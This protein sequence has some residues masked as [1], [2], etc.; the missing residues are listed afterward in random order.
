MVRCLI[1]ARRPGVS[2]FRIL[3]A[4]AIALAMLVPLGASSATSLS[5]EPHA[6]PARAAAPRIVLRR[7]VKVGHDPIKI[8]RSKKAKVQLTFRGKKGQFLNLALWAKGYSSWWLRPPCASW[9]LR[10]NHKVIKAKA[11]GYWKVPRTAKY[12]ATVKPCQRLAARAQLRRVV[13]NDAVLDGAITKVGKRRDV[14]HL[15]K[16]RVPGGDV[17]SA[18]GTD[19]IKYVILPD[20]TT[21]VPRW[22]GNDLALEAGRP[23]GVPKTPSTTGR[24]YLVTDPGAQLNISRAVKQV[25]QVDGPRLSLTNQ[26]APAR[27]HLITFSGQAG[28][29]IY[30]E[31]TGA[32]GRTVPA[33]SK[34]V[35]VNGPDLAYI[36]NAILTRCPGEA[37][38]TECNQLVEGPWQ[39]PAAGT[40]RMTVTVPGSTGA[41]TFGLRLRAAA[42]ADA[43]TVD[44]PAVTYTASSPGQWVIGAIPDSATHTTIAT[45][46]SVSAALTDWRVTAVTGFPNVCGLDP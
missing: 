26:G 34:A 21:I 7:T 15:V 2:V 18:R 19:D 4:I 32:D 33:G 46:S 41:D 40:Y 16:V 27:K 45:I 23:A 35:F 43:L 6:S 1:T 10:R 9:E 31:L 24:H 22:G 5:A 38:V 25:A 14:T 17:V 36:T 39:L 12:V 3:G 28:Q 29:W 37:T 42:V 13:V 44:G 11:P 30:P 8:P 20:A